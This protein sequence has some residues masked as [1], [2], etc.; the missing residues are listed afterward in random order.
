[1]ASTVPPTSR[2][3]TLKKRAEFQRV[4]GGGRAQTS[5]FVI[6]GKL[7]TV[8]DGAA[9]TAVFAQTAR[10]GFTI[11]KKVGNAVIRN[12]IRRRLREALMALPPQATRPDFDYV[13]VARLPAATQDFQALVGDL[14][15]A[16]TT[17]HKPGKARAPHS[18]ARREVAPAAPHQLEVNRRVV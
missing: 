3:Q 9:Q 15:K 5:A 11:T 1:M 6:E 8:P 7:R 14:E 10:F 2:L 17:L 13:V 4:R 12:R 18:H 16:L